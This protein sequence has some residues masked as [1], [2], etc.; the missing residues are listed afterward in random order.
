MKTWLEYITMFNS[1]TDTPDRSTVMKINRALEAYAIGGS[2]R[3]I[4]GVITLDG[5]DTRIG[6]SRAR[7][8]KGVLQVRAKANQE[9]YPAVKVIE[10]L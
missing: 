10:L 7:L 4:Y 6:I 3:P 8:H 5:N 1:T 9:W 2:G